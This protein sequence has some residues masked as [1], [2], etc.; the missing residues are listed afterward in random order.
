VISA[1]GEGVGILQPKSRTARTKNLGEDPREGL[2]KKVILGD[3][4]IRVI[5]RAA[6]TR[7]T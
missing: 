5:E 4:G 7:G 1:L 2:A 3:G 6:R